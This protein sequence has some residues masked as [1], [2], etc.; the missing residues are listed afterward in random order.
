MSFKWKNDAI[1]ENLGFYL[2]HLNVRENRFHAIYFVDQLTGA[3]L[4]SNRYSK[5]NYGLTE[6]DDDLI[7]NFLNAINLFIREIGT[8]KQEEIQE[9]NFKDT[10]ILYEKRGRLLCVGITKKTNVTIERAI[11]HELLN[12]FYYRFENEIIHFKGYVSPKIINYKN[13]LE[14]L[15]LNSLY[16]FN[17]NL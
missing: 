4:V 5:N 9:I 16:K 3:L 14:N 12:D 10:R 15:D 7:S 8:N 1:K 11:L 6:T 17:I 2:K 13:R